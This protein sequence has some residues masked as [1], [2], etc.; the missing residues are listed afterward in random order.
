M[1]LVLLFFCVIIILLLMLVFSTIK[2]NVKKFNIMNIKGTLKRETGKEILIYAELYL[3]GVVK[4]ARIKVTKNLLEKLRIRRDVKEIEKEVES[5]RFGHLIEVIK[6][7]KL[8]LEKIDL[9]LKLGVDDVILTSYL[10]A[11]ISSVI[12]ILI[13]ISEPKKQYFKVL[14]LY[15]FGNSIKINLNCIITVKIVHIIYVIYILLKK[16]R[17][18]HERTSNRRPYDYSYE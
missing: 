3:L 4:I 7:F 10:V 9:N 2:L 13:G 15:N 6:K 18:D 14:P 16:R 8:K 1:K 12:G 11:F 17:K 5:F